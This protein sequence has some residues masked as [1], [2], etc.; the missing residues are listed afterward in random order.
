MPWAEGVR[1]YPRPG[2]NQSSP[3]GGEAKKGTAIT[4]FSMTALNSTVSIAAILATLLFTSAGAEVPISA[5]PRL[6]K[7][8]GPDAYRDEPFRAPY[9]AIFEHDHK[10]LAFVS[11][12]H[13]DGINSGVARTVRW[14][15]K[16]FKPLAVVV[17]GLTAQSPADE[18]KWLEDATWFA[19]SK[20]EQL[21][22]NY[23]PAY[24]AHRHGISFVGGEPSRDEQLEALK[25][26][27]YTAEDL[28]GLTAAANIG[29]YNINPTYDS[30]TL[31]KMLDGYLASEA[32]KLGVNG[33]FRYADFERWYKRRGTVGKP[34]HHI[35][36]D[37]VKPN[38]EPG[39]NFLQV[40]AYHLEL[41]REESAVR[42][43]ESML[44][45]HDR[46]LVVYGS[47]HLV[48]QREVW[49]QALGPSK[50]YKPF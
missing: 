41:V 31:A 13:A 47:G 40:M 2:R 20:P 23:Y 35:T 48:R 24:L 26:L 21:A 28:L 8:L 49:K 16:R 25:P 32:R 43:I 9:I 39:A 30:G 37:D 42:Q 7:R 22:E 6:I 38:G 10:L 18:R 11:G 15:F 45:R 46:V 17:E 34:A 19:R 5:N 14:A 3:E 36:K 50:D 29:A 12:D 44:N 27:G 4:I 1:I 33:G